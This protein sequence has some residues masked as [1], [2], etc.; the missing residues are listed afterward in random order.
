MAKGETSRKTYLVVSDLIFQAYTFD[1]LENLT[2]T[3]QTSL[4]L[5][6]MQRPVLN[7]GKHLLI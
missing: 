7:K 6:G 1:P 3:N 4:V 2:T 5:G